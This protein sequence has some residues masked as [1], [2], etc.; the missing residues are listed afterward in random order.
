MFSRLDSP[1]VAT[2]QNA[3][4]I[5]GRVCKLDSHV[6][7]DDADLRLRL[8]DLLTARLS[9][10]DLAARMQSSK[11]FAIVGLQGTLFIS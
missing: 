6:L 7:S 3:L 8:C 11:L 4:E 5:V 10:Q 1:T 2:R 9:D